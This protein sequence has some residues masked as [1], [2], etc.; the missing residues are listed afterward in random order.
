M[1]LI[2]V[3][4][5]AHAK[6][7]I[8]VAHIIY[9]NDPNW[10]CPLDNM[11]NGVFNPN[12]NVFYKHGD[13]IRWLL[14]D[15]NDK[16]IGRVAAF[17]NEK[18]AYKFEQPTGGMGF[19]ECI[20]DE[21]AAFILF[22]KCMEWLKA[23]GMEAVDGPINFGENDN[24][25]GL[26]VEGFMPQSFGMNY[27][28]P[29]YRKFFEDYGFE[30]YFEQV[31]NHLDMTVPFPERFWK[32]ADWVRQKP[33]YKFQHFEMDKVDKYLSDLKEVY[34]SAW[35]YHENFT[36]INKDDLWASF[37]EA[38]ALIDEE[39]IWFVYANNRPIAFFVMFPDANQILKPMKGKMHLINKLRFF[40]L[41]KTKAI[42]RTRI[43]IMG[44]VPEFQKSGIESGIFW[45][46]DKVMKRKPHY[47]EVELSWVGDFNPKMEALH[48]SVGGKFAKRHIT[49][50]KLFSN[51]KLENRSKVIPMGTREKAR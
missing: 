34:D 2:E 13:A 11:I 30:S 29:Y 21:K 43:T 9:K 51:K 6:K 48:A 50:R 24:F 15:D 19:F 4:T 41:L 1:K 27:H 49:Y 3:T 33:A 10:V 35:Q 32:I 47:K 20:D 28:P 7:F 5:K 26:L 46:M 14:V 45:H 23:K 38:K 31:T 40:W 17:V 36:P 8:K 16:L 42:K 44:V 25:W 12:K 22:D 18:K 39:F 37:R